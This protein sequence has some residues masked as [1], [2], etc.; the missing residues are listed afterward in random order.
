M[1]KRRFKKKHTVKIKI[2]TRP[3]PISSNHNLEW[4][5]VRGDHI[6]ASGF[7]MNEQNAKAIA[8]GHLR[9]K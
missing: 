3:A 2:Q 9:S 1:K 8:L 6:I 4:R 7:A 5:L